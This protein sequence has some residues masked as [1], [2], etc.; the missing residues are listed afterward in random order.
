MI[1]TLN[2]KGF[3]TKFVLAKKVEEFLNENNFSIKELFLDKQTWYEVILFEKL[4]E[5]KDGVPDEKF[6]K[7][8]E[9]VFYEVF[10][11]KNQKEISLVKENLKE[12]NSLNTSFYVLTN[13]KE[14][15]GVRNKL[16]YL[17]H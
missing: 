14:K 9:V 15:V 5:D 2:Y 11:W 10:T 4:D 6:G 1:K 3:S 8:F 7:I 13:G 17:F 16:N 12:K